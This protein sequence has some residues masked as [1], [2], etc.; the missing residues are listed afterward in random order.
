MSFSLGLSAKE[1]A[2]GRFAARTH[3]ILAQAVRKAKVEK[4]ITQSQIAAALGVN[5]SVVSRLLS[6]EGNLTLRTIGEIAWAVGLRPELHLSE[7]KKAKRHGDNT[8]VLNPC[9]E[10]HGSPLNLT[11]TQSNSKIRTFDLSGQ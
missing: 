4:G 5:K 9:G 3:R 1:K 10:R 2:A 8:I 7:I 6:G 11:K